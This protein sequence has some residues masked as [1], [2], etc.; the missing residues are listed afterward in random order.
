M[1]FRVCVWSFCISFVS[2]GVPF[3]CLVPVFDHNPPV[4]GCFVFWD[5]FVSLCGNYMSFN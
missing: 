5:Q 4:F 1:S 3:D 2:L